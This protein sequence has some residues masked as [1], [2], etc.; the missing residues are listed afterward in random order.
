VLKATTATV[1]VSSLRR[2]VR[3]QVEY[4]ANGMDVSVARVVR[5][6]KGRIL[7]AETY[8]THYVLW[9]GRVEIGR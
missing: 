9:N 2:G 5:S 3:E 7:H 6:G 1:Y 4:P 8:R